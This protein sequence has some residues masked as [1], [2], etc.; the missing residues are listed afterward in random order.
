M[1]IYKLRKMSTEELIEYAQTGTQEAI[2]LIV[3]RYR[4]MVYKLSQQYF[5]TWAEK[6][7]IIQ[8]GFVGLLKAIFYYSSE[9]KSNFNT[10]AWMSINSEMKSFL[11]Y[12]NRK[13]NKMLSESVSFEEILHESEE[14]EEGTYFV[15]KELLDVYE[16]PYHDSTIVEKTISM[17][18]DAVSE[19]EFEVFNLFLDKYSYDDISEIKQ[20]KRKKVDNTIQKCKRKFKEIFEYN[21]ETISYYE[22]WLSGR[23]R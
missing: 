2:E 6:S 5:G 9:K 3:E 14:D 10:F 21:N 16:N 7:D 11:T 18:Q 17:L 15:T 12:L 20:M 4:D 23:I 22:N 13:K 19:E 1:I 8:N